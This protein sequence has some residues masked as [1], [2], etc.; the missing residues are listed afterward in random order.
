M[1]CCEAPLVAFA[2]CLPTSHCLPCLPAAACPLLRSAVAHTPR[3]PCPP[4]AGHRWWSAAP[5]PRGRH[6]C[7]KWRPPR[8]DHHM[9]G[10]PA[11]DGA[12]GWEGSSCHW[13]PS[14]MPLSVSLLGGQ[15]ACS[16]G[17]LHASY[18]ASGCSAHPCT[19]VASRHAVHCAAISSCFAPL[20]AAPLTLRN[21][22]A[23]IS[24]FGTAAAHEPAGH[25]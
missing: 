7:Q 13:E 14:T 18:Q 16:A 8:R 4:W 6:P 2:C 24:C 15:P 5:P 12:H 21:A 1:L 11:T 25:G 9:Q 10:A 23:W 19:A 17:P 22:A 3:T 20:L